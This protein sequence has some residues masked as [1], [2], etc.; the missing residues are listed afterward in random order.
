MRVSKSV[1]LAYN[2]LSH[3]KLRSWLSIVGIVIGVASV[4]AIMS[5]GTGM[6]LALEQRLGTLGADVITISPGFS[7]ASG[8]QAGFRIRDDTGGSTGTTVQNLT[9][10]EVQAL[11]LVPNIAYIQGVVSKRADI[12]Y[13]DETTTSTVKGVDT[14]VWKDMET[15][16]LEAGRYL[17]QGDKNVAVIGYNVATE[18]FKQDIPLNRQITIEGKPFRVVGIL[19]ASEGLGIGGQTSS[20][21]YIPIETARTT[22]EDVGTKEFTSIEI[23]VKDTNLIDDTL[24]QIESRLMLVRAV[25][26]RTKDFSVTSVKALQETI[27]STLSTMTLFLSA[28]AA[29]SLLVGAVGIANTM[30]TTVLEKT[31]EIGIMKSI[32]AKNRDVLLMFLFNSGMVG[33]AGGILGGLIGIGASYLMSRFILSGLDLGRVSLGSAVVNP[34]TLALVL[35][36]SLFIGIMAGIIP[37][38]RASK[39]NPVDALRYE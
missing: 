14:K 9:N 11:K 37:A 28:I 26:E 33:L 16:G 27:A 22:L 13:L 8:G 36:L 10:K 24:T 19:K 30:F 5:L 4:I 39:M 2:I 18:R 23:R 17:S 34:Q 20:T 35:G 32:G 1:K 21:V 15:T 38:Y 6:Q 3:S 12:G 25:N 31:K 7:R 29:I